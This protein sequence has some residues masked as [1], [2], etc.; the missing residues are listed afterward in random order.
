MQFK[1]ESTNVLGWTA[2]VDMGVPCKLQHIDSTSEYV[3]IPSATS[4][5]I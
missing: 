5:T 2:A 3:T 1:R 4:S